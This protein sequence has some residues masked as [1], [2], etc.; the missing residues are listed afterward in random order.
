MKLRPISAAY[1]H[2]VRCNAP[3][4]PA[5][6]QVRATCSPC[7]TDLRLM[8]TALE[9]T[10]LRRTYYLCST[11]GTSFEWLIANGYAKEITTQHGPYLPR[12]APMVQ[13]PSVDKVLVNTT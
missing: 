9:Y 13:V 3:F 8:H 6:V 7:A 2:C 11:E 1:S 10:M 12:V 4:D 5:G